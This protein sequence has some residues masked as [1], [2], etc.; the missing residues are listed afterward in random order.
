MKLKQEKI[1]TSNIIALV[2][3]SA[4]DIH[5]VKKDFTY[6]WAEDNPKKFNEIL[7]AFGM[8]TSSF[9]ERQENVTHRTRLNRLV[10]CDR[11]VGNERVDKEWIDGNYASREAKDKYSGSKLLNDLYKYKGL[12]A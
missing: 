1:T 4:M 2:I 7:Y 6:K 9:I 8:D 12:T 10:T 11:W 5:E 3:V